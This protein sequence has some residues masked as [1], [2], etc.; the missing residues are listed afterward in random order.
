ML[1]SYSWM[2]L[3]G[4]L[5]AGGLALALRAA[6]EAPPTSEVAQAAALDATLCEGGMEGDLR[7]RLVT[8]AVEQDE[9]GARLVLALETTNTTGVAQKVQRSLRILTPEGAEAGEAQLLGK[10]EAVPG[11]TVAD[12]AALPRLADGY[13]RVVARGQGA[14]GWN[15]TQLY[16]RVERGEQAPIEFDEWY[17]KSGV[18]DVGGP[19]EPA[20][21]EVR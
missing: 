6:P 5:A 11:Y 8:E 1:R 20:T 4:A 19:D 7:L 10:G 13:F 14:E 21:K 16:V 18:A 12:K 9:R 2:G 15:E 3:G 17:A